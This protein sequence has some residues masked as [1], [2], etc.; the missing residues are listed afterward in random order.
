M[1]HYFFNE[2]PK[3]ANNHIGVLQMNGLDV[4]SGSYSLKEEI[5]NKQNIKKITLLA[6][7]KKRW[8]I[9]VGF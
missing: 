7:G 5:K 6:S 1:D 4:F 3:Y 9:L 2:T 8:K